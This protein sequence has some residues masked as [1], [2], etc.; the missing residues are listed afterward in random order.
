MWFIRPLRPFISLNM[1]K[2]EKEVF[3]QVILS[4]KEFKKIQLPTFL[5]NAFRSS[6]FHIVEFHEIFYQY[7]EKIIL[8]QFFRQITVKWSITVSI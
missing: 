1:E 3:C 8:L 2:K 4:D 5:E 6:K 7:F